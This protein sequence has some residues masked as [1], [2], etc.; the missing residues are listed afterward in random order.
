MAKKFWIVIFIFGVAVGFLYFWN[1][2]SFNKLP[3]DIAEHIKLKSDLIILN[4][5]KPMAE[6]SSPLK[7][8]G[9]A[10]G[11]WFFEA[12]FPITLTNWD[13]LIIAQHYATAKDEWMTTDFVPYE[14]IFEFENPYKEG[15]QEFMQRGYLILHKDNPSGLPENDDALEIP[16]F[17]A[18]E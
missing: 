17:F 9:E 14:A 4:S 7:I 8:T 2:S 10:R 1:T 11:N 13:G 12:S 18:P 3:E 5:P 6:I 16:V 15:D